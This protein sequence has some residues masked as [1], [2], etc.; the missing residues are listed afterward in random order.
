MNAIVCVCV[1]ALSPRT[2]TST[3]GSLQ[4]SPTTWPA[5]LSGT[6]TALPTITPRL[7]GTPSNAVREQVVLTHRSWLCGMYVCIYMELL[8]PRDV[9]AFIAAAIAPQ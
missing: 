1:L 9:F 5:M 8:F 4:A 6:A 7:V 2:N 3:Q